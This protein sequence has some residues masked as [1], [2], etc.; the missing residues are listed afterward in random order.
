M[1]LGFGAGPITLTSDAYAAE[2]LATLHQPLTP[3]VG[4]YQSS[5]RLSR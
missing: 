2:P 1:R 5:V 4:L 3:H